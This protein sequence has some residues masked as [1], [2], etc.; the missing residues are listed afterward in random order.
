MLGSS[1]LQALY[2]ISDQLIHL[3]SMLPEHVVAGMIEAL[4]DIAREARAYEEAGADLIVFDLRFRYADWLDQIGLLGKEVL[5]A[6]N[7]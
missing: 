4:A 5:P 3:V 6:L 2:E 1:D 7:D